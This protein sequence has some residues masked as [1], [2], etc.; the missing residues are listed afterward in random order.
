MPRQFIAMVPKGLS[1]HPDLKQLLSKLKRTMSDRGQEVRWMAP[2]LWHVTIQF[3]GELNPARN[4]ELQKLLQHWN[5]KVD[6]L[7]FRFQGLGAFPEPTQARVL[8]V[9]VKETQELLR[10]HQ[11]LADK[12]R[13]ASFVVD[14]KEFKPHLT[15]ARFRNTLSATELVKLGGRKHFG[16]Y[17]VSELVLFQSVLQGN[18]IKYVPLMRK[19]LTI[20]GSS[21]AP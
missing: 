10:I 3:L 18:I 6:D 9:G 21:L 4:E 13:S 7:S 15:L 19:P 16:D 1:E 11:E 20:N 2:D 14:E 8:W 12:L 5:P 17:P